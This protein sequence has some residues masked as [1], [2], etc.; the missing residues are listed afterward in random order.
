MKL[1]ER[2]QQFAR[3]YLVDFNATA[4]AKRAGY[5]ENTAYSQ[6]HDL[7]K[8]PEIKKLI[9]QQ[10]EARSQRVEVTA[11][12]VLQELAKVAF[13]SV[14]DFLEVQPDGSAVVNL[15]GLTPEQLAAIGEVQVDEYVDGRGEDQRRVKRVKVK[16][17]DKLKA[18]ELVGRHTDVQAWRDRVEVGATTGLAERLREAQERLKRHRSGD[19]AYPELK[20]TPAATST[21]P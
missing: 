18:L 2:Q 11:D 19:P 4:A 21:T 16:M 12:R 14:G 1:N 3:E 7:L 5:S 9:A 13:A 8:H 6:G 15:Q 17:L 10:I 20:Q